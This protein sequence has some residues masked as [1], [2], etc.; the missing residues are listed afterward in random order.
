MGK[1]RHRRRELHSPYPL[2][3]ATGHIYTRWWVHAITLPQFASPCM[4]GLLHFIFG[5]SSG[6]SWEVW[7]DASRWLRC[8]GMLVQGWGVVDWGHRA[9]VR[10][11]ASTWLGCAITL[12]CPRSAEG[13]LSPSSPPA[14]LSLLLGGTG[15]AAGEHREH[16]PVTNVRVSVQPFTVPCWG[17]QRLQVCSSKAN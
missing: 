5:F 17:L 13:A 1:P 14:L 3:R 4:P 10:W 2:L 7:W 6:M 15:K 9:E 8:G 16:I 11:D 12:S